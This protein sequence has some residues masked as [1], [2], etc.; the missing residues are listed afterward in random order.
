M[1]LPIFAANL[2]AFVPSKVSARSTPTGAAAAKSSKAATTISVTAS[3]TATAS[4]T[5]AHQISQKE[6]DQTKIPGFD[7]KEENQQD[8]SATQEKLEEAQMDGF[9]LGLPMVLML[10]LRFE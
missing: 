5:A 9:L 1:E 10:E 4:S 7:E 6:E 8:G 2:F 3:P